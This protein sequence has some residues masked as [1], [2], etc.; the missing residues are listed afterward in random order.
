MKLEVQTSY[1]SIDQSVDGP[2]DYH[3][4][5]SPASGAESLFLAGLTTSFSPDDLS[6]QLRKNQ[7]ASSSVSLNTTATDDFMTAAGTVDDLFMDL[8]RERFPIPEMDDEDE[9]MAKKKSNK[10]TMPPKEPLTTTTTESHPDAAANVYE[11]AKG[12]W[13]WGKGVAVVSPFMGMAEAVAGK[14]LE[15]AGT[16]MEALDSNI[17]PQLK[18]FDSGILNPAIEKVTEVM[19]GAAG[20]AE[21]IIKPIFVLILSPFKM[22]E[23]QPSSETPEV[24]N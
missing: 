8:P 19:L 3:P 14:A 12:V 1:D 4:P 6:K 2:E 11:G 20:K 24:T 9:D 16:N 22:L 21:E 23:Q 17:K 10:T 13:A 18:N 5:L 7:S 15:V